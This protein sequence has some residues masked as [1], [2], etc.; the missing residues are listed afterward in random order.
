MLFQPFLSA[1]RLASLMNSRLCHDLISPI[2]AL[3]NGLELYAEGDETDALDLITT[4]GARA[5]ALLQFFRLA[6]GSASG[7]G[8][9]ISFL[10]LKELIENY[11][12]D[13]KIRV[14]YENP[15]Q[16]L[17]KQQAQF[18]LNLLLLAQA[19][20]PR[21]GEV[22]CRFMPIAQNNK[23]SGRFT[24]RLKGASVVIPEK[25][26]SLYEGKASEEILDAKSIQFY[27]LLLLAYEASIAFTI[28]QEPEELCFKVQ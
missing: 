9:E 23:E 13:L 28:E 25:F 8:V 16:Q 10:P 18:F 27:F 6:F 14:L 22:C 26:T 5:S 19:C 21:G 15:V 17:P 7:V 11:F 12:S 1:M 4:C 3:N 2:G 20:L 24:L